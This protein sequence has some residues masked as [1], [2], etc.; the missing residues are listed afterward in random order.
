MKPE[1]KKIY[2]QNSAVKYSKH[3][4]SKIN[5][6]YEIIEDDENINGDKSTLLLAVKKGDFVKPCPCSNDSISCS[7]YNINYMEGC[8]FDCSYCILQLYLK[9]KPVTVYVNFHNLINELDKI[10]STGKFIR[11]GPGELADSLLLEKYTGFA[12]RLIEYFKDKNALL[13]IKTKDHR[14]DSILDA[15]HAG[16]TVIS[17]SVNPEKIVTNEE[18]FASSLE[19]RVLA[20]KKCIDNN[21]FVGLHFDPVIIYKGWEPDYKATVEYIASEIPHNKIKW[22]SIG[23]LR[24]PLQLKSIIKE[25]HVSSNLLT[26]ELVKTSSGKMRYFIKLRQKGYEYM[27]NIIKEYFPGVNFYYCMETR[28]VWK[29][30]SDALYNLKKIN[31]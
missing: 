12:H 16:K 30:H 27:K 10:L 1:I 2:V 7:Y 22:I 25:N 21:Y 15:E 17:F 26:G 5:M 9:N 18:Y 28:F 14:V 31:E 8:L 6:P 11:L 29:Q 20:L 23:F 4:L 19:N 3:I 24:F 13:E